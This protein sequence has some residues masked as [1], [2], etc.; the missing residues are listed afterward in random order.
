M[1]IAAKAR[2]NLACAEAA[3]L[4][5]LAMSA[6]CALPAGAEKAIALNSL[7]AIHTLTNA[8][9]SHQLPVSFEAT[10]TY[11]RG[12][13]RTLFVQDGD[14]AIYV[15]PSNPIALVPGDRVLIKGTTHESF[16]PFVSASSITVLG[17][18]ALPKAVAA[19]FEELI[20]A[21]FDC[22]L[23]A[24]R[25]TV[26]NVDLTMSSDRPSI[27]LK[28][29]GG[30]GPIEAV[31]DSDHLGALS[32]ALD[33]EVEVTGAAS[34]HFDGK[35][36]Q[37]GVVLHVQSLDGIKILKGAATDPW[38]LPVTPMDEVLSGY[39]VKNL[40]QR[41]RVHGVIT[42]YQ[43]G[44]A[45]VLQD[46]LKS[47][48]IMTSSITPLRVGDEAD[49]T[50]FPDLH[51]G[52]LTLT[53]GEVQDRNIL[54]PITPRLVTWSELATSH[55]IFD[56][57]STEAKVVAENRGAAQDEYVLDS[58]GNLFSAI[59]RHPPPPSLHATPLPP[60]MHVALG[61]TVRVTGIC[62]MGASNPFDTQVPFDVLVR[63]T[64]DIAVLASPSWL[65]V[66]N[67]VR[68]VGALLIVMLLLSGWGWT[69]S[70]K[71]RR[72]TAAMKGLAESEAVSERRTAQLEHRR[73][74]IL[75]DINSSRPLPELIAE[76]AELVSY[77]LNGAFCW[78]EMADDRRMDQVPAAVRERRIIRGDIPARS[79][80]SLGTLFV[81]LETLETNDKEEGATLEAGVRLATLA[82]ET[83]RLYK[84]LVYR[85]EF[86][87][88]TDIHN[89]FSLDRYLDEQIAKARELGSVFGL[90]YIDLDEFKQVNDLYGHHVGDL[91]LQE[92]AMR[93][94]RQLRSGDMLAR[95]G[96][97]EF[98]AL[99]PATHGR[100][101]VDEIAQRLERSFDAPFA[102]EGYVLRGGASV[103]IAMFPE[104][105]TTVDSLLSA[106]DAA[107]YV[108]KH[109][110]KSHADRPGRLQKAIF[111]SE[112]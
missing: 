36:Q 47:L 55:H 105:G 65:S 2:P 37:N 97:D 86:D 60:M 32:D 56:L 78:C 108:S 10:V 69:L 66:G 82:I 5:V 27:S 6:T 52:F 22:R 89:R 44:S 106:A 16:R 12:Y 103:G 30:N 45:L 79:G 99:V 39:R 102:V 62:V 43:P 50:G 3:V 38:V 59:Y 17:H 48:W 101:A 49:A 9:A 4:L 58:G 7:R 15:Q 107:M 14:A 98:A 85:S 80:G 74:Q 29:L 112:I 93:M 73:G 88:L 11:Y 96:G 51:D 19:T 81:A 42:Y 109:T 83:R 34:G 61:S 63:T 70:A 41:V 95:L 75:E 33:A 40:T 92:V 53:D 104:D 90:I 68:I 26:R 100:I 72:Q 35:M 64:D 21:Q 8:E 1:G 71:V 77:S 28:M 25:A 57:V 76:I 23:V 24:V 54:A 110:K 18:G 94:K 91:Y 84:D 111:K 20:R 13:E 87:L 31:V 46:G 67:L